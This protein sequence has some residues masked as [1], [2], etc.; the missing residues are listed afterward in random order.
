M[1]GLSSISGF[2]VSVPP[3]H[4]WRR[5]VQRVVW[6]TAVMTVIGIYLLL[7]FGL[8]TGLALAVGAVVR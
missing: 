6:T 5:S 1:Q 4:R 7:G 8:V 3:P 2:R